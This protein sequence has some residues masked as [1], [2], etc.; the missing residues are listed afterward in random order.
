VLPVSEDVRHWHATPRSAIG[1]VLHAASMDSAALGARR[2][3]SMPGISATVGEQIAA[4]ARVGGDNVVRRIRR[5]PDPLIA[6]IV[7]GWPRN[8][9]AARA[10][11]LGFDTVER[12]FDDIIRIHIDDELG[13]NFVA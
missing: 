5:E 13:G 2:N 12:S 1:F 6:R 8:F 7:A 9:D 4:L 3:L 10:R 11:S